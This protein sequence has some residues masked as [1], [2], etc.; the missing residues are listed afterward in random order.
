[1]K[2][3]IHVC[4]RVC[5][6]DAKLTLCLTDDL[7][8]SIQ[9]GVP[10]Y[11]KVLVTSAGLPAGKAP[12]QLTK[13]EPTS[14]QRGVRASIAQRQV[15]RAW[16]RHP[17][18]VEQAKYHVRESRNYP[19]PFNRIVAILPLVDKSLLKVGE[20][21]LISQINGYLNACGRQKHIWGGHNHGY[22]CLDGLL[23]KLLELH[24]SGERGWWD[25]VHIDSHP[26]L[27]QRIANS[28]AKTFLNQAVYPLSE[29]QKNAEHFVKA[30]DFV[31]AFVAESPQITETTAIRYLLSCICEQ[32]E[33]KGMTVYPAMLSS[34]STW[35]S[36][37]P[38]YLKAKGVV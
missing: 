19:L 33:Q 5:E 11:A 20:Q 4:I 12:K 1:M 34:E 24:K 25:D 30:G 14:R 32:Y 35:F 27:T 28:Y 21:T 6:L 31:I 22:R 16:N 29:D 9:A 7:A 2:Q 8:A 10:T 26:A 13:R 18:I 23:N 36:A 15:I 37:L 38:Q 17:Y 3:E